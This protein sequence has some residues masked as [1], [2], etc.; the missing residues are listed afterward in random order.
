MLL[1][2]ITLKPGFYRPASEFGASFVSRAT[3]TKVAKLFHGVHPTT[4]IG[5]A[6]QNG[7]DGAMHEQIR[8]ASYGAGEMHIAL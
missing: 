5:F 8:V 6:L 1:Y 4:S 2:Q 3:L 7:L